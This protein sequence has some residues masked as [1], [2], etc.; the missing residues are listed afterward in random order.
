MKSYKKEPAT[1]S[2]QTLNPASRQT[3]P[4]GFSRRFC[5]PANG[6]SWAACK[7]RRRRRQHV[8]NAAKGVEESH[9]LHPPLHAPGIWPGRVRGH[10]MDEEPH[11]PVHLPHGLPHDGDPENQR[12]FLGRRHQGSGTDPAHQFRAGPFS[13]LRSGAGLLSRPALSRAGIAARRPRADQRHNHILDRIRQG[14]GGGGG[15]NDGHRAHAGIPGDPVLRPGSV[16]SGDTHR[17]RNGHGANRTHRLSSHGPGACYPA[18]SDQTPWAEGL[19]GTTGAAVPGPGHGRRAGHHPHRPGP[20]GQDHSRLARSSRGHPRPHHHLCGQLCSLHTDR[21]LAA[22]ARRGHRPGVR[23]SDAQ[24]F[25][26]PG[27]GPQRLWLHGVGRRTG[28]GHGVHRPSPVGG[29]VCQDDGSGIRP[30][31]GSGQGGG[32]ESGDQKKT[33]R[34]ALCRPGRWHSE[35]AGPKTC[36]SRT[37]RWSSGWFPGASRASP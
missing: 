12:G 29:M 6:L 13:L 28:G 5:L 23:H 32:D 11:H 30:G 18:P 21:P 31:P 14:Q 9:R 37:R 19:L 8:E 10:V 17:Y 36:P 33:A 20:Q 1:T 2:R 16:G 25:H 22:A 3:K 15:K 35:N 4:P 26:R 7:G 27:R 24:P 34:A